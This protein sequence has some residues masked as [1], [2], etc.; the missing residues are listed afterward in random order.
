MAVLALSPMPESFFPV[1]GIR[2]QVVLKPCFMA[3]WVCR[4]MKSCPVKLWTALVSTRKASCPG[5]RVLV[6]Y[7]SHRNR[8]GG[9]DAGR[10]CLSTVRLF[11]FERSEHREVSSVRIGRI[12]TV[13]R[14]GRCPAT[15][16]VICCQRIC[17]TRVR[18]P[19]D[20][21]SCG[22]DRSVGRFVV[23]GC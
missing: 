22:S 7:V 3:A 18:A 14:A 19:S 15:P 2:S 20:D 9:S 17:S 8:G 10:I 5:G 11:P 23:S 16:W 1:P 12:G 4:S 13:G 21:L 6:W